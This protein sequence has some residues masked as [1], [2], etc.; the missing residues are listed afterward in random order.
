MTHRA[1]LL[2]A[3]G[4]GACLL[5]L[6]M[7]AGA[8]LPPE[9]VG[10]VMRLPDSVGN[11]WL[12]VPDRIL[13][14]SILLD[15]D[16]G[17]MLGAIDSGVQNTPKPPI[18]SHTRN[19]IYNIDTTYSRG[20]R[21][22]RHD[23]VVIYDSRTLEVTGEVEIPP[24]ASD[25]A[26]GIAVSGMLDGER[27]VVVF[28]QSPGASVSIVDVEARRMAAEVQT[29]GCGAVFPAGP[30]R[31]GMLCG[32]GTAITV[33]LKENGKLDHIARTA[34]FFDVVTDPLSEKG[35]R[36]GATWW[37][38]SFEGLLYE[39]DFGGDTPT[40]KAPWPLF[41]KD[42]LQDGWRGGGAQHLAY[43]R[44]TKRLYSVVHQGGPGSHK[45]PGTEIWVYDVPSRKKVEVFTAPSLIAAFLGPQ[46][47]FDAEGTFG[48]VLN[49]LLP[50]AGVHSIAVT[51]DRQPLLF[52]RNVD[53]GAVGV[54]DALSGEHLRNIEDTGLSGAPLV[55]P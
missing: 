12:W 22:E 4:L 19:E 54:L 17:N 1:K 45:D 14:H 25:P 20:H 2:G 8:D 53:L 31:F 33:H 23:Y 48:K 10:Q 15:G 27:F 24:K 6:S 40:P 32:D 36:D 5:V 18:W 30:T 39:V 11:H 55:V 3:F 9:K 16:T 34:S 44:G 21:G 38:A 13:R 42:E 47:G 37:F 50:N 28:N 46:S 26:A 51:Q 29:A 49:F 43:H 52:A 35:V 41:T 7:R